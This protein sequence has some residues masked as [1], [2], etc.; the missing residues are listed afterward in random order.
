MTKRHL[1]A[2]VVLACIVESG[3][4]Q[5]PVSVGGNEVRA[6]L[7]TLA[8]KLENGEVASVEITEISLSKVFIASVSPKT[9]ENV[10]DYKFIIRHDLNL[11]RPKVAS[12]LRAAVVEKASPP[13]D[14]RWKFGF[15]S[16]DGRDLGTLYFEALGRRGLV[17]DV[18]VSY[19]MDFLVRLRNALD[20][21]FQMIP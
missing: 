19:R 3:C 8:Q 15:Y 17:G 4:G 1:L 14:L 10:W 21:S 11:K 9:L 2:A 5:S 20:P 18:P 7:S 6:Q 13:A 16:D 12:T